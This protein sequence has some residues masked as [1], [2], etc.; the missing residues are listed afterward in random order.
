MENKTQRQRFEE[1]ARGLE[2]DEDE[3]KFNA[4]LKKVVKPKP[5]KKDERCGRK[6]IGRALLFRDFYWRHRYTSQ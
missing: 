3:A 6:S 1:T 5:N 2:C 4:K